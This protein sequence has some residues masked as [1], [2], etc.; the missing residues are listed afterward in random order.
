MPGAATEALNPDVWLI[1][2]CKTIPAD[3]TPAEG[4]RVCD[5]SLIVSEFDNPA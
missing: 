2:L 3:R 5:N 1:A 4:A